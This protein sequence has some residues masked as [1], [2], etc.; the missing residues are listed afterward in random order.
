MNELACN[1]RSRRQSAASCRWVRR[2]HRRT[3]ARAALYRSTSSPHHRD[4][5]PPAR[6]QGACGAN[7]HRANE[8][9]PRSESLAGLWFASPRLP[10]AKNPLVMPSPMANSSRSPFSC[11]SASWRRFHVDFGTRRAADD[12]IAAWHVAGSQLCSSLALFF[13]PLDLLTMIGFNHRAR[14]VGNNHE[15]LLVA[16][17]A[18]TDPR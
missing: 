16:G 4:R 9:E 8:V 5:F 2:L 1:A 14:L 6:Q 3:L 10:P 11:S 12:R 7:E 17:V 15:S 18:P 13:Q